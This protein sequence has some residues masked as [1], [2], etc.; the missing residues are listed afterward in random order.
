MDKENILD[1]FAMS[2]PVED[3]RSVGMGRKPGPP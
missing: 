3:E 1:S 2:K